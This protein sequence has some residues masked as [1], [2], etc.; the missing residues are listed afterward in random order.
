MIN[1]PDEIKKLLDSMVAKYNH[2]S[3]IPT[4]PIAVPHKLTHKPD[5]EIMALWT[6]LLSWGRRATIIDKSHQLLQL[7]E[8]SPHAFVTQASERD[9]RAFAHF[10][11]RTFQYDDTLHFLH[12]FKKYYSEHASLEE[13]FFPATHH[14]YDAAG[15]ILHFRSKF[16]EGTPGVDYAARTLKHISNPLKNSSCKRLHMFLRWMVRQDSSGVDFGIWKK[17]PMHGLLCPVDVHVERVARLLG[18]VDGRVSGWELAVALTE[19]L[20]QFDPK[21]PVKYDF[22]LFGLGLEG[23]GLL[24]A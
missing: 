7:L 20:R 23:Y 8:H 12:F 22:A 10:K 9:F 17:I 16:F 24:H 11:H 3:F 15:G 19:A 6:A 13:A 1:H 2:P 21:D 5:I 14:E 4:D 18:M